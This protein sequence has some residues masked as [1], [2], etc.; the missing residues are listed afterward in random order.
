MLG[1][2]A[3]LGNITLN[4]NSNKCLSV[5]NF[6]IMSVVCVCQVKIRKHIRVT[7]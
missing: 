1:Y 5:G 3:M 6:G 7:Y 2:R 4:D